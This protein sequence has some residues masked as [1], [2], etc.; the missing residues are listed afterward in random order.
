MNTYRKLE[1]NVFL[2]KCTERH[3]KGDVIP[4]TTKYGKE[5]DCIVFN[6]YAAKDGFYYYSIVRADG[7]NMQEYAKKKAERYQQWA[8]GAEA[9]SEEYWKAS[10]EG[11]DFLALGEPIKIGATRK[12]SRVL[13]AQSKRHQFIN[14]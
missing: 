11:R 4:V 7:F 12:Q 13:A 8:A 2:A 1:A 14:A 3:E 9:K 6:L 10:H 5:N